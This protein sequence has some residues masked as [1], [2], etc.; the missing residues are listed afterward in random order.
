MTWLSKVD[1]PVLSIQPKEAT[2]RRFTLSVQQQ[3]WL[4]LLSLVVFPLLGIVGA[5][6]LWLKRR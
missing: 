5:G 3:I 1:N 6:A 2:N 4:T